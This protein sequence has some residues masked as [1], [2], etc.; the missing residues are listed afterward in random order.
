[1]LI[2]RRYESTDHPA[3]WE[4]HKIA[5]DAVGANA[6]NGPWNDDLRQIEA[7]YLQSGGDFLV[8]ICEGRLVAMGALKRTDTDRAEI[9]RMRVH[10][11]YSDAK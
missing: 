4:L 8:G 5:L 2:L 1:M 6:G 10:P 11:V 9:K 7:V 3:V